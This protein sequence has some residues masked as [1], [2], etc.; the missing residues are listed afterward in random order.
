MNAAPDW[1]R[2]AALLDAQPSNRRLVQERPTLRWQPTELQRTRWA[3][4]IESGACI[5]GLIVWA[6]SIIALITIL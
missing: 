2:H 6:V 1:M 5:A 4:E 3:D